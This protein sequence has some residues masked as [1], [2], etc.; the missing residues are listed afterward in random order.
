MSNLTQ[1]N[2]IFVPKYQVFQDL[3]AKHERAH[4]IS[5]EAEMSIDVQQ[6]RDGT[7]GKEEKEYIKMILRLFTQA[8]HN[9]CGGYVERLLP[10]FKQADVRMMLLSF[11]SREASSHVLGYKRLND[12]LGYD[13]EEFMSEFLKYEAMA[14]KHSFMLENPIKRDWIAN[15]VAKQMLIEGISLFGSFAM[16][17]NFG[18]EGKLPGMVSVNSWSVID[19]HIHCE[20]LSEIF[21]VYCQENSIDTDTIR[22]SVYE[23]VGHIVKL[24]NE[25]ID[26]CFNIFTPDNLTR[27]DLK[28][29]ILF[30]A[31]YRLNQL[32]F[33]GVF[34]KS[35]HNLSWI[36][37]AVGEQ[38]TNFFERT[39]TS[40]SKN[41]LTGEWSY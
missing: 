36:D 37:A 40:Y 9:V 12:T 34:N 13:S 23:T 18:R 7:I 21:K 19:E 39:V 41:N 25:F 33:E 29:Y 10:V 11:A 28:D 1:P 27:E 38:L 16:L 3:L 15:Y 32:G 26:L 30:I 17:L 4:W 14:K 20:G 6:W 2:E 31:D 24:E 8:D 22:E 5:D 35:A